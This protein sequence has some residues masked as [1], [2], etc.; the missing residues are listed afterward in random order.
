PDIRLSGC[1]DNL[2][3]SG[4]QVHLLDS[5]EKQNALRARPAPRATRQKPPFRP[6]MPSARPTF[7]GYSPRARKISGSEPHAPG[8]LVPARPGPTC[9]V[10]PPMSF[11]VFGFRQERP[12]RAKHSR[13][14][15]PPASNRPGEK[16]PNHRA[17]GF[18]SPPNRPTPPIFQLPP[19]HRI[20]LSPRAGTK[21]A[22]VPKNH[23]RRAGPTL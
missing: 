4:Q 18:R 9:G 12:D 5:Q 21:D 10:P 17:G 20:L 1:H 8:S 6:P 2:T 14:Q 11:P 13:T 7:S 22:Y 15:T 19:P 16:A 23:V 3:T